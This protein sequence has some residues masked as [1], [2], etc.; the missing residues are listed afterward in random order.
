MR[1]TIN[2][3][4]A[5]LPQVRNHTFSFWRKELVFKVSCSTAGNLTWATAHFLQS[6]RELGRVQ[7]EMK[8]SYRNLRPQFLFLHPEI[9][10]W[11]TNIFFDFARVHKF[12]IVL[13]KL[14]MCRYTWKFHY[15]GPLGYIMCRC[16]NEL[17]AWESVSFLNKALWWEFGLLSPD[18][19]SLGT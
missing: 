6:D 4:S 8:C 7:R 2:F 11:S 16:R 13:A 9:D 1:G 17:F 14:I 18:P 10:V 15:L 3:S 19:G 5:S 12:Q